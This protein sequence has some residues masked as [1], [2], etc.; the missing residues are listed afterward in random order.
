MVQSDSPTNDE[1]ASGAVTVTVDRQSG[2]TPT[3]GVVEAVSRATDADPTI[4]DPLFERV[5]PDALDRLFDSGPD[6]SGRTPSGRVAFRFAG[7][8]V[9]VHDDGRVVATPVTEEHG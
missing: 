7:C 4:L 5:D 2:E 6:E 8:E 3:E 9:V 1:R